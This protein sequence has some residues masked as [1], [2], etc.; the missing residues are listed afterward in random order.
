MYE[1]IRHP[2]R[3]SYHSSFVVENGGTNVYVPGYP[4]RKA[5]HLTCECSAGHQM[6]IW[7]VIICM[8]A[9][10]AGMLV[11]VWVGILS[12]GNGFPR[13]WVHYKDTQASGRPVLFLPRKFTSFHTRLEVT[14]KLNWPISVPWSMSDIE[15][16]WARIILIYSLRINIKSSSPPLKRQLISYLQFHQMLNISLKDY[17][18]LGLTLY[19]MHVCISYYWQLNQ[20]K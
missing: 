10:S 7:Q 19:Q 16:F 15:L 20:F 5:I 12:T 17:T 6:Y 1:C 3:S 13:G 9:V 8:L 4:I 2:Y 11:F 14:F 18:E